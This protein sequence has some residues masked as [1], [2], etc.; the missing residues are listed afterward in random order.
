MPIDDIIDTDWQIVDGNEIPS[1]HNAAASSRRT[2]YISFQ[3]SLR[4]GESME[5]SSNAPPVTD[6]SESTESNSARPIAAQSESRLL[7]LPAEI[8]LHIYEF[9]LQ[10]PRSTDLGLH[11]RRRTPTNKPSVLVVL[12]T[13]RQIHF[14]AEKILYQINRLH[15]HDLRNFLASLGPVRREAITSLTIAAVQAANAYGDISQ[16]HLL[17]NLRSLWIERV[18][19]IRFIQPSSWAIFTKQIVTEIERHEGLEEVKIITPET[20]DPSEHELKK[21]QRLR[22]IDGMIEGAV[23]KKK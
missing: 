16:L 2:A 4:A 20:S 12:L 6:A 22:G 11:L 19:S 13:C 10:S 7:A 17:P 8:R 9:L 15:C 21:L 3:V 23:K 14:E 18:Q 5:S 1:S